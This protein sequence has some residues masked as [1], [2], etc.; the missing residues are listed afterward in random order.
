MNGAPCKSSHPWVPGAE[1]QANPKALWVPEQGTSQ[2]RRPRW[3]LFKPHRNPLLCLLNCILYT[4]VIQAPAAVRKAQVS[5]V[6][7]PPS[8]PAWQNRTEVGREVMC[9][10]F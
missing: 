2:G 1:T 9:D 3:D 5:M 10:G 6:D 4:L 7:A 8:Q